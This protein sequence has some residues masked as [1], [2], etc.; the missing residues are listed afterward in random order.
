MKSYTIKF[1][2]IL[3]FSCCVYLGA[4][5]QITGGVGFPSSAKVSQ[6]SDQQ[7]MQLWQQ[8][9]R[10]GLSETEA[11]NLLVKR[12]LPSSEVNNFK[13][14]LVQMQGRSKSGA[15]QNLVSDSA[16]FMRDTSW[17]TEIPAIKRKTNYF[18]FDFFNNPNPAFEPNLRLTTPKTYVLGPDD[19]LTVNYTGVN[20]SSTDVIV[21]ADG[22]IQ[23]PYAGIIA[24][25]GLTIDQ[26]TQ[27]IKAR[28]SQAYP[29]LA[30]GRTQVFLTLTNFKLIDVTVIGEAER[31][32]IYH[33]S[34]LASLFNL[35]YRAGGPSENGSLRKIE[36]I[37]NNKVVET[38]DFYAFLQKGL[39]GKDVRLQDQD[40]IR[41][42]LYGKR[43][44]ITG[45]VRRP[46]IYELTEKETLGEL[47][48]MAGGFE[49]SA[50][51]DVAKVVQTGNREM[52]VRDVPSADFN[53][54][55]PRNGDSVFIDRI[56]TRFSN[57]VIL[58]GAVY[59]PGNYELTDKL[60]L[61]GLIKKADGLRDDVFDRGYIRRTKPD[62]QREMIPFSAKSILN[63]SQPDITLIREDSVVIPSRSSLE[64]VPT[65]TVVG[66]VRA[67]GSF[68]FREGMSVE[69]AILLA[70]GFTL[71]AATHKVEVTRLDKNRSDTLAN[72]L[73][74]LITLD[75]DSSLQSGSAKT[76]LQ[77]LDYVFVPRLL[78]YRSL[79]TVKLRGEVL[80]AGDYALEKRN[81]PVED[82]I[83]RS[84]GLSPFGSFADA[85]VYRK[86]LRVATDLLADKNQGDYKFLLLPDD[87]IFIPRKDPFVEVQGA[88]FNPQI[89][90]YESNRFLSYI[91]KAGGVTD[92]GNLKKAYVQYSNGINRKIDH[93]LFFRNYPKVLPGSKIIVPEKVE[94]AKKG[95]SVLEITALLSALTALVSLIS[96]IK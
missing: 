26:A 66:N 54:F 24:V 11:L 4:Q 52:N 10:S 17:V 38:M 92:K 44:A 85:Q 65:I 35:L 60:G 22:T 96:V 94:T 73:M 28:M 30:T 74:D 31:P 41:F 8:A 83:K 1:V 18:G 55:I 88:V 82:L 67:P 69:D 39:L 77:P 93:F 86:G 70:G 50:I 56:L 48:Q 2:S 59:R 87:S 57:R 46:A 25:S 61:A 64:D 62:G 12:G 58:A 7:I 5:A 75:I 13:R 76:Q 3:F 34:S 15:A 37:R 79:G 36:L 42:P 49:N 84:G 89:L 78:N 71:D 32:G 20:E 80:Y 33:V 68:E 29:A 21:S 47:I 27:K 53:Y 45:E 95:L 81:E 6:M 40:I 14:R 16:R 51:T 43:V 19:E 23:L 9:Q 72:K 90:N 63:G 91:S